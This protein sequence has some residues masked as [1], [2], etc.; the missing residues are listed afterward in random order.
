MTDHDHDAE[1]RTWGICRV[2]TPRHPSQNLAGPAPRRKA[3]T[4]AEKTAAVRTVRSGAATGQRLQALRLLA[5]ADD[6]LTAYE[7]SQT[8][9]ISP[10]QC[11]ATLLYLRRRGL[12]EYRL[13]TTVFDRTDSEGAL[14]RDTTPGWF[15]RVQFITVAGRAMIPRTG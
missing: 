4:D 8:T 7:I 10:N 11:G 14:I 6:G 1:I 12:V 2:C 15:G 13:G 9:G 3:A 5:A